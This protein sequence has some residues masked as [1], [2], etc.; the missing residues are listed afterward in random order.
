MRQGLSHHNIRITRIGWLV[1]IVCALN[2]LCAPRVAAQEN[3]NF[4][5]Y[6]GFREYFASNP[7]RSDP[8]EGREKALLE[9]HRP[10]FHLP[11]G[12][13]GLISFYDDY[14]AQGVLSRANG[15]VLSTAVTRDLL[16]RHRDD[17]AV[18]FAHRP[19]TS[20]AP[21]PVVFGRIDRDQVDLG[22]G[23]RRFTFLTYHAVFRHSGLAAGMAGWQILLAGTVGN[24]NDW[25]QLDH[26]TAATLVLD[27]TM[28]PI[29]LLVQQHNNQRTYL[30]GEG[31]RLPADGRP[32]IDVAIRSNELYPHEPGRRRH[33]AV[34]YPDA[35]AMKYLLG[36]AGRPFISADDITDP[37][38]ESPYQLRF[39]PPNDAFYTFKG[40]LGERRML[41]GRDGPP[42]A[43]YNTVPVLKPWRLQLLAGYWRPDHR[44]DGARLMQSLKQ[45]D[46]FMHMLGKQTKVF[47]ANLTCARRL[48][49]GCVFE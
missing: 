27:E 25:H 24:L 46:W 2:G 6:P 42:G 8:P 40:F 23:G 20:V 43:D 32:E 15:A 33:K 44:G 35:E 28:A 39:L 1:A 4:S 16:N 3:E 36:T 41:P 18:V 7:P 47:A 30:L 12:H 45:P 26:Y 48:G 9:R 11:K 38:A 49:A 29:A 34:R 14:I 17:P 13:A 19:D 21:R 10:R 31:Y 5:Q 37:A 22:A